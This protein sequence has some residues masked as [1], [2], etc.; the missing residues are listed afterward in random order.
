MNY[1]ILTV[2]AAI[3]ILRAVEPPRNGVL[4][5]NLRALAELYGQMIFYRATE[6]SRSAL[7]PAQCS[8][9]DIALSRINN[10]ER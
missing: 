1:S 5:A 4:A 2:E 10:R 6:V 8:A 3:N 7:T 9:V